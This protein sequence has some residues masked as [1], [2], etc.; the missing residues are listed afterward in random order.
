MNK[1]TPRKRG[2]IFVLSG[3]S[4][5]GKTTLHKKLLADPSFKK[6][7]VKTVSATTRKPR[8][9]EK[10]KRDYI[11]LTV[12]QFLWRTRIAYFLEWQKVFNDYYGTPQRPVEQLLR[13][14]KNV[15]L[16]IEVKGAKAIFQQY[17]EATGIF[18][19]APDLMTLKKRLI[20]RGS[21]SQ[22]KLL[23]RLEVAKE[24]MKQEKRYQYVIINGSVARAV[25]C[26]K[27]IIAQEIR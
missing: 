21:E 24:E 3:P 19:K 10:N 9:G 20:R 11:F 14:G 8:L 18:V 1:R 12:K 16:C 4:G 2:R 26:L 13:A 6:K 22:E 27:K 23:A 25:D 5:S 15:L 17:P 7:I